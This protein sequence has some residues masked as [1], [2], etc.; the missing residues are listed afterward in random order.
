[1]SMTPSFRPERPSYIDTNES[2]Q[3]QLLRH[4]WRNLNIR[5]K[6]TALAIALGTV[7][8]IIVGTF[9]YF[10]S[11]RAIVREIS[12][13]QR[14]QA[15]ETQKLINIFMRDRFIDIKTLAELDIFTDAD[16]RETST[17]TE[18]TEIIERFKSQAGGIYNSIG[19]FDLNGDV[20]AETSGAKPLGN[21]INRTYIQQAQDVN[22]AVLGQPA[23]SS[24]SGIFSVYA[25]SVIKDKE[26]NEV[27]GYVRTRVPVEVLENLLKGVLAEGPT[28][29]DLYLLDNNEQVFLGP[30]G[31]YLKRVGSNGETLPPDAEEGT[32]T[33]FNITEIFEDLLTAEISD[34]TPTIQA[35]TALAEK[36]K[37]LLSYS[38]AQ[39]LDGLPDLGWS[40]L[41]ATDV[42]TALSSQR[43]LLLTLLLVSLVVASLAVIVTIRKLH[44]S[45]DFDACKEYSDIIHEWDRHDIGEW[46]TVANSYPYP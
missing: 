17:Q 38:G 32:L 4:W 33:N 42:S 11:E 9:S 21:H 19:V 12:T 29:K 26:T 1:M 40:T 30:G 39:P 43:Q 37:Q 46:T 23:I 35:N 24:S 10:V 41:L 6:T 25:A 20:L 7:P 18:R 13:I 36:P 16:L 44:G 2:N 27:V 5:S 15:I 14:S 3:K 22:G 45:L 28:R 34:S 8:V 31:A